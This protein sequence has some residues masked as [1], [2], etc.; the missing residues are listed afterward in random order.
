MRRRR[1]PA[2]S[3][4]GRPPRAASARSA[5]RSTNRAP[6]PRRPARPGPVRPA[7]VRPP[8]RGPVARR[9]RHWPAAGWHPGRRCRRGHRP[10]ATERPVHR[11]NQAPS[12][13]AA[14]SWSAPAN[15]T[16]TGA[17]PLVA[18]DQHGDVTGV[19]APAATSAGRPPAARPGASTTS[20]SASCSPAS[21]ARSAPGVSE[22]NAAVR[23]R[24]PRPIRL[25]P[26]LIQRADR[27]R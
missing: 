2:P 6:W 24:T 17:I 18:G 27:T 19:R 12:S 10:A 20:R 16:S 23:T 26:L 21:L 22:V 13:T 7:T 3:L 4:P 14:Q 15:A 9:G 1:W 11:L 8:P 5:R 25:E